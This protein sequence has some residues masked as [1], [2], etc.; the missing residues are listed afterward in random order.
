VRAAAIALVLL[1]TGS[2]HAIDFK[3]RDQRF[4]LTINE[5]L[6]TAYHGDIPPLLI[7]ETNR[8]GTPSTNPKFVDILSRLNLDLIWWRLRLWTRFDTAAYVLRPGG[9]CGPDATTPADLRSRYCQNPFYVEKL[10]LEYADRNVEATLGD[11]YVN[12]GRGLVLSLRK[13]DELGIDTTLRGM[14]FVYHRGNAGAT[15]VAGWTNV[16]NVDQATGRFVSDPTDP[17]QGTKKEYRGWDNAPADFI[18]GARAE[19]RIADRVTVGLHEAGGFQHLNATADAPGTMHQRQDASFLY[20]VNLD[21][22]RLTKW[23]ALYAEAAG[24]M[25]VLSDHRDHGYAIYAAATGYFGPV[26]VLIEG[27][28]YK[29]Y[30][31][32]KSWVSGTFAEFNPIAYNQPPT[33]ERIVTEL[34]SP[35]YDVSGARARVD[36]RVNNRLLLYASYAAFQDR[37]A[38]EMT[39]LI[40]HDPYGGAEVRWNNGRSHFFPSGGFRYEMEQGTGAEFQRIGHI[41]WDFTQY[42]PRNVSLET[43]GF[44]LFRHGDKVAVDAPDGSLIYP[45][46]TEGTAYFAV[47]WAPHIVGSLGFEWTTRP[48]PAA[49]QYFANGSL[50]WNFTTASSIRLFVGG[51]RGGLRCISG[52]CRDFPAFSGARLELVVRL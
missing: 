3:I 8:D 40:Y 1:V 21:A 32:W 39:P 4:R 36:Y 18:A 29:D 19:Y 50:Q 52:V 23:L 43:A 22:P 16:Q 51:N 28:H 14:R 44:V 11:F 10:A 42:L 27:K 49:T 15:I 9:A 20:G 34:V 31:R 47:K 12:F 5:T 2:A 33:A 6:F 37:G 26:S 48:A 38:G 25:T 45:S 13:L 17:V 24:Q 46:W 7:V 35:I 30:Q 41:E